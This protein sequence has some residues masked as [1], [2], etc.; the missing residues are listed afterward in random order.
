[1]HLKTLS[2]LKATD[3]QAVIINVGTK[4]VT[5]LALLRA[6]KYARMPVI[7]IDCESTDGSLEHFSEMMKAYDFD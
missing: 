6:L 2:S 3:E 4:A 5:T 7:V 1:M